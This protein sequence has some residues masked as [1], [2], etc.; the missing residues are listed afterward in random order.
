MVTD[1]LEW[2]TD[3]F[4]GMRD[5]HA[6]QSVTYIWPG[7]GEIEVLHATIITPVQS[8]DSPGFGISS[9]ESVWILSPEELVLNSDVR[10]PEPGDRIVAMLH[11][12]QVTFEVAN[13]TNSTTCWEWLDAHRRL[14]KVHTKV[15][16]WPE[17]FAAQQVV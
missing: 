5:E 6:S 1:Y 2:A 8:I 9:E 3:W 17:Y 15:I 13:P 7:A 11:G 4:S 14:V 16:H 10:Y 12:Q